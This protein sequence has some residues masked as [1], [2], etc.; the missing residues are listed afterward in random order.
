MDQ[1]DWLPPLIFAIILL[2]TLLFSRCAEAREGGDWSAVPQET[3]EWIQSLK[4]PDYPTTSCCG[5]GDAYE[6]DNGVVSDE[7]ANFCII[8]GSRGNPLPVGTKLLIGPE[9]IQNKQGNPS[10]HVIVFASEAGYVFCFV[11]NGGV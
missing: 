5:E 2:S 6:C 4:R 7:G 3:R 10:G 1:D 11:P 9:K 8:T